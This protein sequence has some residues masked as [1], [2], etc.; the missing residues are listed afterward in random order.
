MKIVIDGF[1]EEQI[2][3]LCKKWGYS[4][5]V[6]DEIE[7]VDEETGKVRIE[8]RRITNPVTK[9]E[10]IKEYV[11][12]YL[13]NEYRLVVRQDKQT[14]SVREADEKITNEVNLI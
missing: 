10:F 3:G 2:D 1:T 14:I 4:E 6:I 9:E 8:R 11:I 13:T 7:H 5:T 12:R